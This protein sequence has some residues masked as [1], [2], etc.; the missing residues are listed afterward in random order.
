MFKFTKSQLKDVHTVEIYPDGIALYSDKVVQVSKYLDVTA[1]TLRV[2]HDHVHLQ[3]SRRVRVGETFETRIE[4]IS[5]VSFYCDNPI[6]HGLDFVHARIDDRSAYHESEYPDLHTLD[7]FLTDP[8]GAQQHYR[9]T[10]VSSDGFN[11]Y[12][13]NIGDPTLPSDTGGYGKG[14]VKNIDRTHFDLV[15]DYNLDSDKWIK[16]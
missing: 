2:F 12:F 8:A 14:S 16:E 9:K 5:Y 13:E 3:A 11:I 10:S 7:L 4:P 1:H 6:I 15:E